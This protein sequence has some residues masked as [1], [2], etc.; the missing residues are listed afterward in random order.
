MISYNHRIIIRAL[1]D[2][3]VDIQFVSCQA[4]FTDVLDIKR[5]AAKI[6]SKLLNF[7]QKQHYIEI[8]Q[9]MLTTFNDHLDLLK[10][11][12]TGDEFWVY[13]YDIKTKTQL[14]Q[15]K[16]P[17]EPKPK[18]VCQV[19]LNVKVLLTVFLECSGMVHHEFLP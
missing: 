4:I 16:R 9:D 14:S 10:R 13:G 19:R 1:D 15:W 5:T 8:A 17:E 6:A 11:I 18:K 2:D 3:D 7:K 12:T